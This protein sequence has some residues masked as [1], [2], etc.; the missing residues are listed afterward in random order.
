MTTDPKDPCDWGGRVILILCDVCG[1]PTRG[2]ATPV[3]VGERS[4]LLGG[5]CEDKP[6]RVPPPLV[7]TVTVR[8]PDGK[9]AVHEVS[10]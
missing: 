10:S 2:I 3:K 9:L 8:M 6:F 7:A 4:W 5:C 1:H